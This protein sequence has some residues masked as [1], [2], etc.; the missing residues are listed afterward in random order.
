MTKYPEDGEIHSKLFT[1][2]RKQIE[3]TDDFSTAWW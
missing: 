2:R 3:E 1:D